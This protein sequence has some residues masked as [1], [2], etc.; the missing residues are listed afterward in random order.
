MA[1][2]NVLRDYIVAA[3][4][5]AG[6]VAPEQQDEW[7]RMYDAAPTRVIDLLV[8]DRVQAAAAPVPADEAYPASWL[9]AG[10]AT[11][12]ISLDR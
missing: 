5:R 10:H 4:I 2:K 3:A 7:R 11:G 1:Q 8:P 6:R 12:S 9:G